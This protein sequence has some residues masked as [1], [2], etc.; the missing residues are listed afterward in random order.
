MTDAVFFR[1]IGVQRYTEP[2][3]TASIESETRFDTVP[4]TFFVCI[5]L[6]L[7][8]ISL[9]PY[10]FGRLYRQSGTTHP[11]R[12]FSLAKKHFRQA[13][14]LPRKDDRCRFLRTIGVYRYVESE[15]TASIPSAAWLDAVS[16]MNKDYAL[17]ILKRFYYA[18]MRSGAFID[19]RKNAAPFRMRRYDAVLLIQLSFWSFYLRW[20]QSRQAR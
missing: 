8:R 13:V 11:K 16:L 2:E 3:K 15:K 17:S 19:S 10:A 20:L 1:V 5:C 12:G 4:L 9:R 6:T 18:R 14:R 7:K